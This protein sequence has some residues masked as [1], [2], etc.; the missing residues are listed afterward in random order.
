MKNTIILLSHYGDIIAIPFFLILFLY[1]IRIKN[2]T[3][4]E[5][6]LMLF[7]LSGFILDS[8]FTY[9]WTMQ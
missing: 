7:A 2:K 3:I 5:Y 1:F 6:I 8:I 9:T 4:L